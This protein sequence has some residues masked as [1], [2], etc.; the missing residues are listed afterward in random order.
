MIEVKPKEKPHKKK[1]PELKKA[2][3]TKE[4]VKAERVKIDK[5]EVHK[6][7]LVPKEQPEEKSV[8]LMVRYV[9]S[10]ESPNITIGIF[11]LGK[12][13]T[14]KRLRYSKRQKLSKNNQRR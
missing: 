6:E 8:K 10:D 11:R 14:L 7:K 9:I 13:S 12:L 2:K 4:K 3:E 1:K 5:K